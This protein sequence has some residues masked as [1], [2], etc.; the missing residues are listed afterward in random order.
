MIKCLNQS[1]N[2]VQ[3]VNLSGVCALDK[4]LIE[5]GLIPDKSISQYDANLNI[6]KTNFTVM[7]D[8]LDVNIEV[9]DINGNVITNQI[10]NN[11]KQGQYESAID[12]NSISSGLYFV[13]INSG[14]YSTVNKLMI[15]K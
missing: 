9:M 3:K 6:I 7:F 13:R 11:L 4:R 5:I 1:F 12:A 15:I 2:Q 8:N 10:T 14:A